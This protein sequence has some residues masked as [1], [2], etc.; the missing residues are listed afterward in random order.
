M[1]HNFGEEN[2]VADSLAMEGASSTKA[3]SFVFWEV[4]SLFVTRKLEAN[5]EETLFVRH[6]KLSTYVECCS[7]Y[8]VLPPPSPSSNSSTLSLICI[9]AY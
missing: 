8:Y 4:P 6:T 3:N 7:T 5:K 9:D 2:Q 1:K